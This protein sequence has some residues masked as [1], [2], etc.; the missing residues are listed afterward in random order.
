[1]PPIR[2]RAA[3]KLSLPRP[4]LQSVDSKDRT[5]SLRSPLLWIRGGEARGSRIFLQFGVME[6][7]YCGSSRCLSWIIARLSFGRCA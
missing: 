2:F 3:N 7:Y 6:N 1:M 5:C 4:F